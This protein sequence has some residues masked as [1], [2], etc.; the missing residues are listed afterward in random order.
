MFAFKIIPIA[1][2]KC[3]CFQPTLYKNMF[4]FFIKQNRFLG[5]LP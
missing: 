2:H 4:T 3:N 1:F 5:Q